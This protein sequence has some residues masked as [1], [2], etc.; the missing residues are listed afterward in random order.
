MHV[1]VSYACGFVGEEE[2]T[3]KY[4]NADVCSNG[5]LV[6]VKESKQTLY[7]K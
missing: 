4:E 6:Q 1:F 5:K 3:E 7:Y 2:R